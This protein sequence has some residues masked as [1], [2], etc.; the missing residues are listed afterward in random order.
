[1]SRSN[2]SC[3]RPLAGRNESD[4]DASPGAPLCFNAAASRHERSIRPTARETA[5][6]EQIP[7]LAERSRQRVKNFFADLDARL[8]E[9]PFVV[10]GHYSVADITAL[11]AVNFAAKAIS[12]VIPEDHASLQRWYGMVSKR[13]SA[14]A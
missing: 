10:G 4:I 1:L 12:F 2:T 6:Y 11:V 9:V 14:S 13:P 8:G 5:D 3:E 7:E